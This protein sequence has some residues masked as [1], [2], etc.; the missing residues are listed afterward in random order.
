MR[1]DNEQSLL[2]LIERVKSNLT[3]VDL[4]MMTSPEGDHQANGLNQGSDEDLEQSVGA[5]IRQSN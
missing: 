5:A 3:G 2:S 1:S 4:V